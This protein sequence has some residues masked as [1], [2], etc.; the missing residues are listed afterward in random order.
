MNTIIS[1]IVVI[2]ML[3]WSFPLLSNP[4]QRW[5]RENTY[6]KLKVEKFAL[7]IA[8]IGLCLLGLTKNIPFLPDLLIISLLLK[9]YQKA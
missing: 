3:I 9:Q 5:I 8:I 4:I 2:G 7:L 1:I 6:Y